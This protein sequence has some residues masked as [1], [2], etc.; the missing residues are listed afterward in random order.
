MRRGK[1]CGIAVLAGLFSFLA[2]PGISASVSPYLP[3]D[4]W[5]YAYIDVLLERGVL[6]NLRRSR[7]P[8][9]REE[10]LREVE[11]ELVRRRDLSDVE[12]KWLLLL[13]EELELLLGAEEDF[14]LWAEAR[15]S[16]ESMKEGISDNEFDGDYYAALELS[17][18]FPHGTALQRTV[19]DQ[20]L[21]DDPSYRGRR[22]IDIA[23]TVEDAYLMV[24]ASKMTLFAGR[25]R[26]N[27]GPA[28]QSLLLSPNPFS[29]DHLS[30][31]L[32][33]GKLSFFF[34]TA[35]LDDMEN[36][37]VEEEDDTPVQRYLTIH[38]LDFRP[39]ASLEI[40]VWEAVLYGGP[41]RGMDFSFTNPFS[42]Y[43]VVE[44]A[45]NRQANS[46]LGFDAYWRPARRIGLFGQLLIDDVKLSLFGKHIFWEDEVEPNEF[47]HLVGAEF[48]D[49]LGL[50][51]SRLSVSY[52]KVTNHTYGSMKQEE[53]YVSEGKPLGPADGNDFDEVRFAWLYAPRPDFFLETEY[54]RTRKGEGEVWLPFPPTFAS[55]DIPFPSGVVETIDLVSLSLRYQTSPHFYVDGTVGVERR[56]NYLHVSGEKETIPRAGLSIGVQWKNTL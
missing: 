54:A 49:P 1:A 28:P 26:R 52:R 8:Y 44:N 14:S 38:R 22:D 46:L 42:L 15:G 33:L 51:D 19:V 4:H 21:F 40:G 43:F 17:A 31:E 30:F 41:A 53:R 12:R 13:E 45:S 50:R 5:A 25:T 56:N 29:F 55:R 2:V 39:Q 34:L 10:I 3:L 35:R 48:I 6:E 47:A 36:G 9:E 18:R 11:K 20:N 16:A 27:L 32:D 7:K 24:R 37:T 23:G